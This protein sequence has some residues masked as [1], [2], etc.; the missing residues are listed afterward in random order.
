MDREKYPSLN[1]LT[2][3]FGSS[4]FFLSGDQ[5]KS[6]GNIKEGKVPILPYRHCAL[7]DDDVLPVQELSHF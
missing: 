3:Y 7:S 6:T 4:E 1:F 5:I 2:R